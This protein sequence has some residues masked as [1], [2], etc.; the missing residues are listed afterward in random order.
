MHQAQACVAYARSIGRFRSACRS[1]SLNCVAVQVNTNEKV[2][3]KEFLTRQVSAMSA[4][5]TGC[6]VGPEGPAVEIGVNIARLWNNN[7]EPGWE[8]RKLFTS[9][10]L[11]CLPTSLARAAPR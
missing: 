1:Q 5:G 7:L 9:C 8:L 3:T 4:L 2:N 10:G 6:S 11:C